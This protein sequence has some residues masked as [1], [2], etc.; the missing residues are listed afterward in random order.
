MKTISK[1]IKVTLVALLFVVSSCSNDDDGGSSIP[2]IVELAQS[3]PN[4]T[5]LVAA[6]EKA[7]LVTTLQSGGAY[8]VLAP[9]NDAFGRALTTLGFASLDEIDTP[10]EIAALR[11][12]LLNHVISGTIISAQINTGYGSTLATNAD[13]DNLSIYL[14]SDNNG[15]SFNGMSEVT[16]AD[17]PAS[18]GVVHVVDEVILPPTVVTFATA[19]SNFSSLVAALTRS[20]QPAFA[21]ILA[22]TEGANNDGFDPDFTVFAPTDEAFASLI[23][24]NPS[25]NSL[26]DID[27]A[28]LTSVLLHHVKDEANIRSGDLTDGISPT[29]LEGS[30][31]INLPGDDGNPAKITDGAGNMNIAVI[32]VDVQA[33]NGVIHVIAE[34]MIPAS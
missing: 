15:V 1:L 31:T 4:L 5:S 8:T 20:D 19:D 23:D 27:G 12:I 18:N 32:A 28:L 16:A 29:M 34:V 17:L 13:G 10:E 2:N 30:I 33:V 24:S 21:D 26:E 9:D 11:N 3:S 14:K 7:D 22:R 25:W 6:L